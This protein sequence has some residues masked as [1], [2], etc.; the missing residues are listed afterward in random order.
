MYAEG[1]L[2]RRIKMLMTAESTILKNA[3]NAKNVTGKPLSVK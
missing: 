3:K 2:S 1:R